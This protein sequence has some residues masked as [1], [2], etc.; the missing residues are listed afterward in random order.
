MR[1]LFS[2]ATLAAPLRRRLRSP[3]SQ[4]PL[5]LHP[6]LEAWALH[7]AAA[8]G[9]GGD[10]RT[11]PAGSAPQRGR[12][13]PVVSAARSGWIA[14]SARSVRARLRLWSRRRRHAIGL[15]ELQA[16]DA[17]TLRDLG[18]HPSEVA[19]LHAELTRRAPS[20]RRPFNEHDRLRL[21]AAC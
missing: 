4:D 17:Q 12:N 5:R 9:F 20:T 2:I 15:R 16:L 7:A 8:S 11:A 3:A 10:A 21:G 14:R 13:R 18:L 1:R 19:S 6:E